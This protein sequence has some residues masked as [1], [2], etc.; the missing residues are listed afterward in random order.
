MRILDMSGWRGPVDLAS[1]GLLAIVLLFPRPGVT[2]RPALIR[3]GD[4][5]L[6]RVAE[7]QAHLLG[8]PDDTAAALELADFFTGQWRPDW[9][10][11]T[12]TPQEAR[13]PADFRVSFA[14]AVAYADR[15][16]FVR[17]KQA[18]DRAQAACA[19]GGGPVPCGDPD[20]T[21]MGLFDHAVGEV[22]AQHVD[23]VA[24]PNRAKEIIDAAMHNA[25]VPARRN[26]SPKRH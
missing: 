25:K 2:V 5:A 6:D 21:R 12:L 17:A 14:I 9:A 18:I 22:V 7:L 13:F 1:I 24:D 26:P 8:H 11:A 15:F 23:P 20:R 3:A 4:R 16:D 10:L 19:R